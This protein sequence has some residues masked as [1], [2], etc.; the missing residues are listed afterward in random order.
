MQSIQAASSVRLATH[1]PSHLPPHRQSHIDRQFPYLKSCQ[2]LH[3]IAAQSPL[4]SSIGSI[5]SYPTLP[6]SISINININSAS[7]LTLHFLSPHMHAI[8]HVIPFF[9]FTTSMAESAR[10]GG[11]H[12]CP[13]CLSQHI[14]S[15]YNSMHVQLRFERL[16]NRCLKTALAFSST[17]ALGEPPNLLVPVLVGVGS[18]SRNRL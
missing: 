12:P 14:F 18:F 2:M 6:I 16:R 9:D 5:P 13:R 1:F 8:H 4:P 3:S 11:H 7:E 17:A 15:A 10:A